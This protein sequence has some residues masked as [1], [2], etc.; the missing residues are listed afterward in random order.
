MLAS[1]TEHL[2][3]CK[4][5]APAAHPTPT[6]STPPLTRQRQTYD[7][8]RPENATLSWNLAQR[9]NAQLSGS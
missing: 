8:Q 1:E 2:Y 4:H 3:Q 9:P 5:T 7:R 6:E